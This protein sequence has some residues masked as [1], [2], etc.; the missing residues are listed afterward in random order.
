VTQKVM[1]ETINSRT[2]P[3]LLF[4]MV[5]TRIFGRN[6][7][8]KDLLVLYDRLFDLGMKYKDVMFTL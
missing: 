3:Y 2:F 6:S 8:V 7:L 4:Q 1:L 5:S